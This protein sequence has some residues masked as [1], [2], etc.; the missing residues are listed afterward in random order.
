M[1]MQVMPGGGIQRCEREFILLCFGE[2]L[3]GA[4]VVAVGAEC[5]PVEVG[6]VLLPVRGIFRFRP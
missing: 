6:C 4:S 5:P 2:M 1:A 3:L